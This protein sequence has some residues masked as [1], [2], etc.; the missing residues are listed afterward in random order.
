MYMLGVILGEMNTEGMEKEL[1]VN[2]VFNLQNDSLYI[3]IYIYIYIL[4][5]IKIADTNGPLKK[6]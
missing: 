2:N 4:N 5:T 6:S 1:F 3:Y